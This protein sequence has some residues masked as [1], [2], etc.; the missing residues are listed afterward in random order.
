MEIVDKLAKAEDTPDVRELAAEYSR[1]LHDG[2]S[3]DKI[4]DV[5]NIRFTRWTGQTTDGRKHSESLPDGKEAF[6]WEGASDTRIPLADQIINDTVDVLTTSFGRATLK[7][8]GTEIG[9][10]E[11]A[12]VA[13]SMMRW[14]RDTK[15]YHTLNRE[16]EL[17]AQYGQQYGWSALFV[18]WEQKS[19]VKAL[20]VTMDE[21]MAL[22]QQV[23]GE[24]EALPDMINDPE[25]ETH[26]AEI[27]QAQFPG[28]GTSKAR[29]AVKELRETGETL[30]PQ[31]YL[32]V[33][34]PT[35]VALKP[36]EEI[37]FP[38]ETVDLQSA[39][40]IFRRL[41][42]TEVELRA[43][44]VDEGW[45]EDWVEAAVKT[46]GRSTEFHDFGVQ[47]SDL[48]GSHV[49]RQDNLI[50]VVYAYSRQLDDNN[51]PG[52]YYTIF[53]PIAQTGE[54]G[55]D[56]HAKHE[57]LDYVHCRYPFVEYRRE[58]LKRRITESR[59]VPE[60]CRTWQDEIKTQRD[61]IYDSTSFETLPPI[62]VNKRL[63]LANKVGPAVQLPVMKAGDYEFM[64][65]PARQPTTAFN[66]IE[67]VERQ[68][69]AYFG[70]ANAGV[71]T[72]QTQLKQQR[73]VNNWLIV[74]TEAY[75]QMFQLS[76][77]YLEPE[78]IQ[79]ITGTEVVPESDMYQF[80]FVLKYDVREL[81]TEYVASKLSNIA[82]YVVPQDVSGVL[83][84]NKLIGM[85]TRAISPDIAEELIIDQ[86]PA[87]KKMYE[88]VKGQIGQ[89]MLGNEASYTEND[90]AAQ[91]KMQY[92]QEIV[93]RNPKAQQA[94]QGDELFMQ[95]FEN[96]TK[97]LQMSLMQQ[98]NA[99]I[100]R[101]G[102]SQVT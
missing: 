79:R 70:R 96:Y 67:T 27:L 18:G 81:D 86:A 47:L 52:I 1:S 58:K 17:L 57:L 49:D 91:T 92:A 87:S 63:G 97:N 80:D 11:A 9:D 75:Q 73:L 101:I 55:E 20:K 26:V 61:S 98:Q 77:Q 71:P 53:S 95:L 69:D 59:G 37:S 99:Q 14:Q 19:A 83:D 30:L 32:A 54:G 84:R 31:A 56:I 23:E 34:Q 50:E 44:V 35:I 43:K 74:W 33:N 41:F 60:I 25:S 40:V 36:W 7:I 72:V 38:P 78:E 3:L 100:G 15:L 42:M 4:S 85:I 64:R 21:I 82:Q 5:D 93:G 6:P 66:L 76:L 94:L 102:V 39:R 12:G 10:S 51:I 13:S 65:P 88:D 2:E 29:K 90:P 46:G 16:S 45:N 22:A 62:M 48:T 28:L 8:G 68:A 89:M 24:L